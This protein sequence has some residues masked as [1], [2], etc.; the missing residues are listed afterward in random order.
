MKTL[1]LSPLFPP[2]VGDPA[3]Y[4]KELASRLPSVDTTLLVYGYLPETVVG[5]TIKTVDKR[6]LLL[7]RLTSYTVSLFKASKNAELIIINNA[8][9]TELPALI[10]SLFY[11]KPMLLCTSDPLAAKVSGRGLYGF[12]HMLLRR[13]CK[14]VI[15]L[16][17]DQRYKKAEVLPFATFD[18]AREVAR[19]VWWQKHLLDI[20]SL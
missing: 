5:V 13:R 3:D 19:E 2:D 1:I 8:P 18:D 15:S 9:S 6:Q 12:V 7:F 20:Q 4:V 14:K 11:T 16:P 10:V 17:T